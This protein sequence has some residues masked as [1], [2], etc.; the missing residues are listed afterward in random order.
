MLAS[1][2]VDAPSCSL[3]APGK[4]PPMLSLIFPLGDSGFP[5]SLMSDRI[6]GVM[7]N[8]IFFDAPAASEIL[9]HPFSE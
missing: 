6:A 2:G 5:S 1:A 8:L 9:L 3:R 7:L 4:L